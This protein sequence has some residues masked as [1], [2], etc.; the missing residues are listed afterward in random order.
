M[1]SNKSLEHL[2]RDL[3]IEEISKQVDVKIIE[4]DTLEF[5]YTLPDLEKAVNNVHAKVKESLEEYLK[6]HKE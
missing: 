5:E 3:F 4:T 1:H 2:L 6:E